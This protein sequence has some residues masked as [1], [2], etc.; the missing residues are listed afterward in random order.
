MDLFGDVWKLKPD[1]IP[2]FSIEI[3]IFI[4]GIVAGIIGLFIWKN[5]R[6]LAK[7]GLPECVIGFFV[8]AFHAFFDAL[9]T[10]APD[11]LETNLDLLD[12]T[13]SIIG[14]SLIFVGIIRISLYGAKIWSEK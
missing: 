7:K 13:F 9:D 11:A 2:T 6:I 14:L 1:D 4:A 10:I 12:S 5:Y 8:F 3:G